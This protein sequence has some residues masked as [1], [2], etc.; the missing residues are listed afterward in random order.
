MPFFVLFLSLK[1]FK[2]FSYQGSKAIHKDL[3]KLKNGI[4]ENLMKLNKSKS[5]MLHPCWGNPRHGYRPGE[6]LIES[7]PAE[8]D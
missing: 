3:D 1:E 2:I 8:K 5:K 7:G 4:H 6:D